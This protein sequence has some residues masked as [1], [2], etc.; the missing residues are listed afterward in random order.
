MISQLEELGFNP[1]TDTVVDFTVVIKG[2]PEE[3][4]LISSQ[5]TELL[6]RTYANRKNITTHLNVTRPTKG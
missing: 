6:F 5:M 3:Q 4:A 2:S 1:K